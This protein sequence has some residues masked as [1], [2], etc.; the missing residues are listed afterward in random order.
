MSNA[1]LDVV[2]GRRSIYAI[3]K[4]VAQSEDQ[5]AALVKEAVKYSPS[6]FN[7][8][9]SRVVVLFGHQHQKLWNIT[10]E[11]LRKIVPEAAFGA[12]ETKLASFAAGVGTVLFFEDTQVIDALQKQFAAYADNFPVWSEHSTGIAQFA[13]WTALAQ[14][15][16]GA[17]LQHYNPLIDDEVKNSWHLPASW[18]LRAQMPFGSIEQLAGEKTFIS[19]EER[20]RVFK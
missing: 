10:Q 19:D 1:F 16:I 13:V 3:G 15:N 12:T 2:K 17:T 18:K 7:S 9:S 20:F 5:I 11:T 14:E 6:S 4:N 8:Q